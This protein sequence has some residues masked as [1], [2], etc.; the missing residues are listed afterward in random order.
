MGQSQLSPHDETILFQLVEFER[1]LPREEQSRRFEVKIHKK[2]SKA[3][4]AFIRA[5][6]SAKG[7]QLNTDEDCFLELA[8]AGYTSGGKHRASWGDDEA[9]V[10]SLDVV[11]L[12]ESAF[13]Y[14][15]EKHDF[16]TRL[17]DERREFVDSRISTVYPE[18]VAY[19]K[20]AYDAIQKE[21]PGSN[22]SSVAHDCQGALRV[23]ADAV[24]KTDYASQLCE[25]T[26]SSA[27]FEKKLE[28]II[29]VNTDK[30]ELRDLLDKLNRYV[31]A[32]RH[33]A[34]TTREEAKRCVLLTYLLVAE[35]YELLTQSG[36]AQKAQKG[37]KL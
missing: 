8:A 25:E 33:D 23:F 27:D 20:K 5:A 29:R 11:K 22:W 19:L 30:K 3:P 17:A 15:D 18:V 34:G 36:S 10:I 28:Q 37:M 1:S 14:Y 26:P 2:V 13:K 32:R 35:V 16:P 31:N 4:E 21:Q 9:I 12:M 24:Y 6:A 7:I